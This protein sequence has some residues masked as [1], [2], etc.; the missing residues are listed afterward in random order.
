[1]K[2]DEIRKNAFGMPYTSPSV[3]NIEY[4]MKNREYLVISYETDMEALREAVP[5]PLKVVSNVIKMEFM[6]M[7][8]ANG[9]GSFKEAGQQ[10]EVEYDGKLGSY[11][12]AMYLNDVAPIVAGREIWGYP[13]K[14]ANPDLKIDVDTLLGTLHYN[15]VLVAVGSMGYKYNT[16][17]VKN[18]KR[19]IEG[20]PLFML[21][22]IPHVNCKDLSVCQLTKCLIK[23]VVVHGAW[24]SPANLQLFNHALAPLNKLP[25]RKI[26][27]STHFIADIFLA[28]GEVAFD[29]LS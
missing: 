17:D 23:D 16:L 6:K 8:D 1:M 15:S 5:E 25:V 20:T 14:Y 11:V 13:K 21:K 26:I 7:P 9:F 24:S 27:G 3:P 4:R 10:I 19:A 29:Y 22:I 2:I 18:I 12:H 28:P